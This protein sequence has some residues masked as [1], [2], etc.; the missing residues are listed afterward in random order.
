MNLLV[1]PKQTIIYSTFTLGTK[2]HPSTE[3]LQT[4]GQG[5]TNLKLTVLALE[6]HQLKNVFNPNQDTWVNLL[7]ISHYYSTS[8]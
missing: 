3:G 8:A 7:T 6:N 5:V 2:C 4:L 1:Y